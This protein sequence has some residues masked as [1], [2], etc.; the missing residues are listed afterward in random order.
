MSTYLRLLLAL[1]WFGTALSGDDA[2]AA[3]SAGRPAESLPHLYQQAQATRRWDAWLD[4]GLCA[5]AAGQQGPAIVWL[6]QAHRLAPARH[7]PRQALAA[8]GAGLPEGLLGQLGPVAG[9]GAGPLALPLACL[10]GLLLGYAAMGRRRRGLAGW[11][12]ALALAL[13][14]PGA[15]ASWLDGR[16]QWIAVASDTQLLDSTGTPLRGLSA[17]TI[18]ERLPGAE[19]NG[20]IPVRLGDG[21]LG[22]LAEADTRASP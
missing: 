5:A 6:L 17:G 15:L 18:G 13:I 8:L 4:L 22:W 1:V 16:H 9:P 21:A 20:R 2:Y 12:G 19:W 11:A 14:A 3:W 7:E 10:A